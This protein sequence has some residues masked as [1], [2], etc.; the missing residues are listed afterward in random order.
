MSVVDKITS[1][2]LDDASDALVIL[3]Q[4]LLP[5]EVQYLAL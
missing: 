2:R 5:N 3:D 4:T 1:V